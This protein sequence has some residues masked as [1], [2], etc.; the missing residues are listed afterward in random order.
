MHQNQV[1][2]F[3]PIE[4]ILENR[5]RIETLLGSGGFGTIYR[6]L[7]MRLN[8]KVAIKENQHISSESKGQFEREAQIL[9]NLTHPNLPRVNDYF[10]IPDQ[11]QYLVMDYVQ[12]EDLEV[13]SDRFGALPEPLVLPLF[14]QICEAVEYLHRQSPPIIHRDIKPTNIRLSIDGKVMLV[15]FGIA[16]V[17]DPHQQTHAGA[18]KAY[19]PGYSPP[20]QYSGGRT[21]IQSDIYT[22]GATLYRLLTGQRALDSPQRAS[23]T[24]LP[25]P[26]QLN[27]QIS[28]ELEQAILKAINLEKKQRFQSI[29]EL[30]QALT[31][32]R[33]LIPITPSPTQA[34][35]AAILPVD[36]PIRVVD[37][38]YKIGV[39]YYR[40]NDYE[41]AIA[42]FSR[43]ISL[44]PKAAQLYYERAKT[45]VKNKNPDQ[46]IADFSMIIDLN[47][48][49]NV[50]LDRAS[51]YY[52][53]GE[54]DLAI[55]DLGNWI[56]LDHKYPTHL[57]IGWH[58]FFIDDNRWEGD[59]TSI[60]FLKSVWD[61][62]IA[63]LSEVISYKPTYAETYFV[64]GCMYVGLIERLKEFHFDPHKRDYFNIHNLNQNEQGLAKDVIEQAVDDF[65]QA[66]LLK[67]DD[68]IFYFF[69]GEAYRR[70]GEYNLGLEDLNKVIFLNPNDLR[71][72]YSRAKVYNQ[73][74]E[75]DKA[76]ADLKQILEL[77]DDEWLQRSA[78]YELG[79]FHYQ[80]SQD[81]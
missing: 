32:P 57:E 48:E 26:R 35:P 52:D 72:Y 22:L 18:H 11:G 79:E 2:D 24:P 17:D 23:G 66:I 56:R 13:I 3:L 19:S 63:H 59:D 1:N 68:I 42:N 29:Q 33:T 50:Y 28:L 8:R 45:Y 54:Y 67:P 10:F 4:S 40:D 5:Y 7:D 49:F 27:P 55:A 30:R 12:G 6:A 20:E 39:L 44:K 34:A 58:Q 73:M 53:K 14:L 76:V 46:A 70:K 41:K 75:K 71:A 74:G 64:R 80:S 15:D 65:T 81:D 38:Y 37:L 61:Q 77:T 69:R 31:R 25:E 36:I 62:V 47:P 78:R 60:F 51:L 21:D 43:A 9:A 16:K